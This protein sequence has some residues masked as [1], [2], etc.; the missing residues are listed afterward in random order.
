MPRVGQ[1]AKR[2]DGEDRTAP[3]KHEEERNAWRSRMSSA[4]SGTCRM[5]RQQ[6][7]MLLTHR[8][9]PIDVPAVLEKALTSV[10]RKSAQHAISLG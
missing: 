5:L 3:G 9:V 7:A 2:T 6:E 10:G 8:F 1:Q 4:A